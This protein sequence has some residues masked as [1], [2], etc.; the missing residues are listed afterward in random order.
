VKRDFLTSEGSW[1]ALDWPAAGTAVAALMVAL[2][3]GRAQL[4]A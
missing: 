3:F 2:N 4:A 1:F